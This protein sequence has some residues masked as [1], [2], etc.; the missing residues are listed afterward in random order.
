[1]RGVLGVEDVPVLIPSNDKSVR[2]FN[3]HATA[4]LLCPHS[5]RDEFDEDQEWFCREVNEGKINISHND[6]PS[7]LY[8]EDTYNPDALD[9]GLLRGPLLV[10]ASFCSILCLST[11][12][13][14]I[15]LSAH[16]HWSTHRYEDGKGEIPRKKVCRRHL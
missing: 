14:S 10:L 9:E 16:I 3:H 5:L 13:I 2:R 8:K 15:V 11:A 4:R 1:M 7:F 12:D 6:W